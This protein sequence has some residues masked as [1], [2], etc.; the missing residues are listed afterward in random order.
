MDPVYIRFAALI[1]DGFG[2]PAAEIAP[3]ATFNDLELD[4]IA[5]V[6]LIMAVEEEF[7]IKLPDGKLSDTDSLAKAVGLITVILKADG[8]AVGG[9]P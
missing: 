5:L 7:G 6:E 2:V 1:A 8:A 3:E 9:N 4:S